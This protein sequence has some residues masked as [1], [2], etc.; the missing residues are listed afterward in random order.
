MLFSTREIVYDISGLPG[1]S[2]GELNK[3][4][5]LSQLRETRPSLLRRW[6]LTP[7]HSPPPVF[8]LFCVTLAIWKSPQATCVFVCV[9]GWL[10]LSLSHKR[11]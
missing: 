10:F 6:E 5:H 4:S 2:L 8:K 9:A 7:P 1:S 11:L 3:I